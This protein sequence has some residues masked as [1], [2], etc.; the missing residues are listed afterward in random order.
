LDH[1]PFFNLQALP[2]F[3][4]RGDADLLFNVFALLVLSLSKINQSQIVSFHRN[5]NK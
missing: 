3:I 1:L 4:I 5:L 2:L